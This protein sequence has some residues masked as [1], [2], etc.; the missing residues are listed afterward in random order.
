MDYWI[1][2]VLLLV[3]GMCLGI[4]EVF[5]TSAGLLAFLSAAS[6]VAAVILGFQQG[7]VA[8]FVILILAMVGMPTAVVLAFKYWPRTCFWPP[9]VAV[10]PDQRGRIARGSRQRISKILG[11]KGGQ[12]QEQDAPQWGGNSRRSQRRGR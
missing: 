12:G 8:G 11:G 2:A 6:I 7:P 1:W 9:G 10:G 3:V 5:F 4:M